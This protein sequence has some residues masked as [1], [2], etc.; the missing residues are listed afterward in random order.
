MPG[1]VLTKLVRTGAD[2]VLLEAVVADFGEVL[3]RQHD[4]APL[5]VV[6]KKVMKSGHG[7]FRWK[8]TTRG[9]TISTCVTC[10]CRVLAAAP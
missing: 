2:R 9:S 4:P 8:R 1:L 10:S 7:A 6:P 5:A 3:L